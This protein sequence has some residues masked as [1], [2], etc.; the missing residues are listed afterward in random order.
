MAATYN[1]DQEHV[2]SQACAPRRVD[3]RPQF[4][5]TPDS[6]ERESIGGK[7]R[8]WALCGLGSGLFINQLINCDN[9]TEQHVKH[10]VVS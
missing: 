9:L 5:I 8:E 1:G 2:H 10:S 4:R 7:D 3:S 6:K